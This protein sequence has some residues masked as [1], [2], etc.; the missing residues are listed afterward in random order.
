MYYFAREY[1]RVRVTSRT[2]QQ[3]KSFNGIRHR[4]PRLSA[5]LN[6]AFRV[7]IFFPRHRTRL[8]DHTEINPKNLASSVSK[9]R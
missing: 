4:V 5:Y 1:A 2:S 8:S 3:A 7:P 6:Y 9:T